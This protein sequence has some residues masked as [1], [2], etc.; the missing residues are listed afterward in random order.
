MAKESSR[1]LLFTLQLLP[2]VFEEGFGQRGAASEHAT[3]RLNGIIRNRLDGDPSLAG[4]GD[5][6]LGP[7]PK[8]NPL[9]KLGRDDH[10]PLF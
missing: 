4:E 9:P 6:N 5:Q 8:A 3:G 2:P 7:W 1:L 10:L